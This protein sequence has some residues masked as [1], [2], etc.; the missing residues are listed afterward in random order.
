MHR[1]K[2]FYGEGKET[3]KELEKIIAKGY[4]NRQVFEDWLDLTLYQLQHPCKNEEYLAVMKTYNNDFPV[5]Q[6][7]ADHFFNAGLKLFEEVRKNQ[8]DVLG[9]IFEQKVSYGNNG[10]FLTPEPI[11]DLLVQ[12]NNLQGEQKIA[13][14]ACGS[15]RILLAAGKINPEAQFLW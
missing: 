10:Q 8:C 11:C 4:N 6:R 7:P 13:D 2:E 14:P 9:N 3:W 5:G 12:L 1:S 15:G